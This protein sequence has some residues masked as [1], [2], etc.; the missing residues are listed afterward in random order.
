MILDGKPEERTLTSGLHRVC[1]ISCVKCENVI[2]WKY[3][4]AEDE[5][6]KYKEQKFILDLVSIV[7]E[8]CSRSPLPGYV[9]RYRGL[10]LL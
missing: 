3:I 8:E 9:R 6:Q 7:E 1:D 10:S 2:G 5:T 4:W